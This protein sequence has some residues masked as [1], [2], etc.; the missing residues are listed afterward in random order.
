MGHVVT[1][2]QQKGGAGKTTILAHL[3]VA[4]SGDGRRVAIADLD[5]QASLTRWAAL[6][7]DTGL[8]LVETRDYRAGSDLRGAARTHDIVLV[9]CPGSASTMLDSAIRESDLVIAPCQPSAMDIWA[10]ATILDAG[11]K[12]KIPVHILFNRMPPRVG[13]MDDVLEALGPNSARLLEAQLGNRIAYSRAMLTGHTGPE[14]ARRSRA[15]EEVA[16]LKTEL[17]CILAG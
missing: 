8:T 14:L 2:A 12:L 13:P 6:R 15:A 1:F 4:W 5:P 17:D 9:D 3:A 7:G 11:A 10:T 16:V